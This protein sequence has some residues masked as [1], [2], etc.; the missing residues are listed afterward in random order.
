MTVEITTGSRNG[1]GPERPEAAPG[2][3]LAVTDLAVSYEGGVE[4]LRGMSFSLA[5]GESLA[6]VGESGAGKTTLAHCLAGLVQPPQAR[7]S[8][9]I[10]GQELLAAPA[11]QLRALRWD[12]VALAVQGTPFNPVVAVGEQVSEPL[13]THRGMG[14]RAARRRAEELADEVAL[15]P[16]LLD[17]FPHQ[18]SGGQRRL[19][20]LAMALTLDPDLLV[21]DEPTAALDPARRQDLIDRI[22]ALA[23]Q[24]GF[25]L[26]VITHDLA[27][28]SRLA[29]NTLVLYAGTAVEA[30]STGDVVEDAAHPYSA[31]LVS[32][33]PVMTTTKDLRPIRGTPP[34]PREIPSGCAYHPRCTQAES[35]CR[36]QQPLLEP[37]RGRLVACHF[38]GL[39]TLLAATGIHKTFGRGRRAVP[40]LRGVS[41]RVREGEAVGIVGPS[42]SGKT[43]LARVIAGHVAADAGEVVLE[44]TSLSASWRRDARMLRRR[45]QLVLQDPADG[46]S[47]RMPVAEIVR[48][49]LDLA[50]DEQPADPEAAVVEVLASVG[51]PASEGFLRALAHELSGGQ[52]QRV[53]LARA[54]LARPKLLVAD[55]PTSMLDASEQARLLVVLRERQVELGIGLVLVSHDIALVRKVTDR[56]L[57]M[58]GGRAVEQGPSHVVSSSP[59]SLTARRMVAAA[60]A[61]ATRMP[62]EPGTPTEER[63]SR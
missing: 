15:D 5:R 1:S 63:N 12:T 41:L 23:A 36:Q 53:S 26:I 10:H 54:L 31:A 8:V 51:L 22:G 29:D 32:A 35:I 61:F 62:A 60:P 4:A 33:Y 44:G 7:G 30:G 3:L 14:R 42:G 40:A 52:Q 43:T 45:I 17:R 21:L 38:G 25:G 27:D 50:G 11:E 37:S 6:I 34:D 20:L 13:R 24:R 16:A 49:A 46:L 59:Q 39:K 48:E 18:L 28:A 58:D 57:V 56:I 47:P 19:A 9:R 2:A 55:E